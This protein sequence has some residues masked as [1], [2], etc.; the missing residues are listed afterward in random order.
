MGKIEVSYCWNGVI[1]KDPDRRPLKLEARNKR[2]NI[3]D[4]L[5]DIYMEDEHIGFVSRDHEFD[6]E[7]NRWY[8]H[9]VLDV[10]TKSKVGYF[11][12]WARDLESWMTIMNHKILESEPKWWMY[13]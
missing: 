6:I 13:A 12:A 1:Y 9:P 7:V 8:Y 10:E 2:K 5:W 4:D 3:D 11:C